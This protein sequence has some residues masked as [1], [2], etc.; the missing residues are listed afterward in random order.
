MPF[1]IYGIIINGLDTTGEGR[2]KRKKAGL[3]KF[4]I[5]LKLPNIELIPSEVESFFF[6]A[7]FV[8]SCHLLPPIIQ[9]ALI[10]RRKGFSICVSWRLRIYLIV[11]YT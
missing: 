8:D 1:S 11:S 3:L 7:S 4:T 9:F 5:H 6:S 2:T 10:R